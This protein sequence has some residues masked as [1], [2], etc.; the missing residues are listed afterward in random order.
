MCKQAWPEVPAG[1]SCPVRRNGLGPLKEAVWPQHGNGGTLP[2]WTIWTLQSPEA[3]TAEL[4]KQQRWC[5]PLPLPTGGSVQ[6]QAGFTHLV[7][8]SWLEFQAS[9]SCPVRCRG[10]GAC[11]LLLLSPLDSA[12]FLGVYMGWGVS[13][14][15]LLELHLLLLGCPESHLV[16]NALKSPCIP[17]WGLCSDSL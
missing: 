16:S 8:G 1:R 10:S 13:P 11:R 6:P 17:L 3:G 2:V 4:T 5:P 15:S 9:G 12:F 14:P 7:A